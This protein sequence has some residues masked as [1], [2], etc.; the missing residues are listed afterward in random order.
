M[1]T[2]RIVKRPAW[3]LIE[4]EEFEDDQEVG[5]FELKRDARHELRRMAYLAESKQAYRELA[6]ELN[7]APET[8][9]G[10]KP[11]VEDFDPSTVAAARDYASRNGLAFPPSTGDFDRLWESEN[12]R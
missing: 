10:G 1:K 7:D 9:A 8:Y 12:Y 11:T 4:M 5:A 6:D 3:V 2:Y